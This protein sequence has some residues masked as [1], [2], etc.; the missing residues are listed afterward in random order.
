MLKLHLNNLKK[1]SNHQKKRANAKFEFG[2]SIDNET[3]KL[4]HT[5]DI[6][7]KKNTVSIPESNRPYSVIHN[8]TN[9]GG[10]SGGDVYSHLTGRKQEVCYATTPKG[11]WVMKDTSQ[12]KYQKENGGIS[13]SSAYD[14][15]NKLNGKFRELSNEGKSKYQEK[16]DNAKSSGE[17]EKIIQQLNNEVFDNYNNWLLDEFAVGKR[18]DYLIEIDFIPKEMISNVQF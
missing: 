14:I 4:I 16:Y 8:H 5:K 1:V 15:S 12:A 11:I 17:K 18:R 9:N 2:N 10:F 6:R 7:G 13:D 3:G